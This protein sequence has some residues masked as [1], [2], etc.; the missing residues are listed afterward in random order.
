MGF[1]VNELIFN[2]LKTTLLIALCHWN[3]M[4]YKIA[5]PLFPVLIRPLPHREI[6]KHRTNKLHNCSRKAIKKTTSH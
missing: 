2:K 1:F 6:P 4:A 3:G 5:H